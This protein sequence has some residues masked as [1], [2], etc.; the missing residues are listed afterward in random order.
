MRR[1][2]R[3][4]MRR[5]RRRRKERRRGRNRWT[6]RVFV[7]LLAFY[8]H[9]TIALPSSRWQDNVPIIIYLF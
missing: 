7:F 9:S 6:C 4:R 2:V 5:E 3:R 1:R 8:R